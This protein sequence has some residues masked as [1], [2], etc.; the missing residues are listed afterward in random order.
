MNARI[1]RGQN[2]ITFSKNLARA[3]G[4]QD[5]FLGPPKI[6]PKIVQYL[7]QVFP[8]SLA[9]AS[10]LGSLEAARGAREV[11]GHLQAVLIDQEK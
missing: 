5:T 3:D 1:V 4:P 9:L 10:R 2:G 7:Q 8:D 11:I 6:D